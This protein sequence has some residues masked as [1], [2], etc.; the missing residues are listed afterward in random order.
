M[1]ADHEFE[2][3]CVYYDGDAGQ[4]ESDQYLLKSIKYKAV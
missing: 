4:V 3:H 1:K 2:G